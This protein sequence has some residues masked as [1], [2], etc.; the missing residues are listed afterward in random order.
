MGGGLKG[1]HGYSHVN[2]IVIVL[3]RQYLTLEEAL[4]CSS[5]TI[6]CEMLIIYNCTATV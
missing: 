1:V 4:R 3:H 2:G 5:I 6:L